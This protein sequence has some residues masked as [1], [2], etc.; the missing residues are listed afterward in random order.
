MNIPCIMLLVFML[1]TLSA[2]GQKLVYHVFHGNNNIGFIHVDRE[3]KNN[4]EIYQLQSEVNFR[5]LWKN[6]EHVSKMKVTFKDGV[7]FESISE[8]WQNEKLDIKS[9][10]W[11]NGNQY[12]GVF[13]SGDSV[14][15][16]H[17]I[18]LS[19]V[20]LYYQEPVGLESVF[21]ESF[22]E[23]GKFETVSPG[24]YEIKTPNGRLNTYIYEDGTLKELQVE[25]TWFTIHFK[26]QKT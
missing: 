21:L 5:I 19:A 2:S 10:I 14:K 9:R 4:L 13:H 17:P 16:T 23:Y 25:G 8:T 22:L 12:Q 1:D 18:D 15:I 3:Q 24:N 20:Q 7:L 6:H 11:K 26:K